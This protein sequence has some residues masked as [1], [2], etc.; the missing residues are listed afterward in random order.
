[1]NKIELRS[2]E[3]NE[4]LGKPPKWIVRWG[5]T[6]IFSVVGILLIGSFVFKYP[7]MVN[8]GVII[9]TKNPPAAL[10]A[11]TSGKIQ[12]LYFIQNEQL[13]EGD[14]IA[15]IENPAN[16]S[17]VISLEKALTS[18][19]DT[20][21]SLFNF[22][23]LG[24]IQAAY[25]SFKENWQQLHNFNS[26]QFIPNKITSLQKELIGYREYRKQLE[27]QKNITQQ[28]LALLKKQYLRDSS[29]MNKEVIAE[30]DMEQ[31]M[32]KLLNQEM[33]GEQINTLIKQTD[34]SILQLERQIN[35][36]RIQ[37]KETENLLTTNFNQSVEQ[38]HNSIEIWKERYTLISPIAGKLDLAEV[39]GEN[40]AVQA[41]QRIC[42][43]IP[44]EVGDTIARLALP[45]ANAGK[46]KKGQ[47]VNIKLNSYPFMEYG[48]V[49][50]K[51]ETINQ[52][53]SQN[54]YMVEASLPKGLITFY[55]TKLDFSQEMSG[56]AE[57]VTEDLRL[58]EKVFN[59]IKYVLR[60]NKQ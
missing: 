31:S 52:V 25:T 34:I 41:G 19:A 21:P 22:S 45:M 40:Q 3:I 12:E 60:K 59:P 28:Q 10:V 47:R 23:Q 1:M 53:P 36:L 29:L 37:Q 38:L 26:L 16:T 42:S 17:S 57:I 30:A 2:N 35:E 20:E 4:I 15:V 18:I 55:G 58:I 24:D 8:A 33:A 50:G 13:S 11:K 6:A 46:V 51:I 54:I 14:M 48:I 32:G 5:I 7:V 39:W 56:Q 27:T 44:H 49:E 43:V 9:T